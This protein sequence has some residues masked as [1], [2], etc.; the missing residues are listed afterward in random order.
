VSGID[1]IKDVF[2]N[3]KKIRLMTHVV[4]GYPDMESCEKLILLMAEKGV[5]MI[6]VQLPFSD[7]PA[8]GPVIV[9]ANHK[10]LQQGVTTVDVFAMLQ[11][12]REKTDVPLLIMSYLN[13]LY[14]FGIKKIISKM[15]ELNLEGMIVPDCAPEEPELNLPGLCTDAGMAFVPL[16]A[17]GTTPER[18][19]LLTKSTL[20]P[21][22]YAVLRLGVTGKQTSLDADTIAYLKMIK[23]AC[24]RYV[25]GGFGI[26]KK[27]QLDAMAGHAECGIIGSA[28]LRAVNGAIAD[29]EDI[30]AVAGAFLDGLL[31]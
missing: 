4:G 19:A 29:G 17:P 23:E 22:V 18:V 25:A 6:E 8:D 21:F 2:N 30:L 26:S 10:A 1:R 7:P 12:V 24:G 11:R 14:A 27:S 28:L 20:S 13:P 16:V 31:K 3:K 5:D 15:V 9:A